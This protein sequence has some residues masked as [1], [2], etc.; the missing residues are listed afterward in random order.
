MSLKNALSHII[1]HKF[2]QSSA[3][4]EILKTSVKEANTHER[5]IFLL[6][7]KKAGI[8]PKFIKNSIKNARKISKSESF[9]NKVDHLYCTGYCICVGFSFLIFERGGGVRCVCERYDDVY[10]NKCLFVTPEDELRSKPSCQFCFILYLIHL[11][12]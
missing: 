6:E 3:L 12:V 2:N 11:I 9:Q 7:C 4:I 1:N 8:I 5:I 10:K